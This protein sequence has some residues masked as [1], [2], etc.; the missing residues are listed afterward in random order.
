MTDTEDKRLIS[1]YMGW[2]AHPQ[3]FWYEPPVYFA[4]GVHGNIDFNLNDAGLCVKEMQKRGD[5]DD[6]ISRVAADDTECHTWSQFFAWLY[7]A[8]N[9]FK[10]MAAWLKEEKK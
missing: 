4:A 10:A 2:F 9:F 7:D 3:G 8:D 6:F 5:L 1:E